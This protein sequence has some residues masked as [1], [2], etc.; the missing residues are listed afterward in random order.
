VKRVVIIGGGLAGASAAFALREAGFDGDVTLVG[1]ERRLPYERPPLSKAYLRGDEAADKALVRSAAEYQASG[2]DLVTGVCAVAIDRSAR[3]VVLETERELPFDR[4]LLATGMTARRLE[5]PG[6]GLE[7]VFTLRTFADADAIRS[8]AERADRVVVIGGGWIGSEVAA[9]LR[10]MGLAV[11]I[12]MPE[13]QPLE[14]VL[15][16]EVGSIYGQLHRDKGVE[17]MIGEVVA[18]EGERAARGVQLR[19]GTTVPAQLTVAG[20]GATARVE[21][22]REAGLALADG[23]IAVDAQLRTSD[24]R[25]YAAGDV[26]AAFNPRYGTRLRVEHWDNAREQGATAA[27]NMCG[28]AE[29]Y[30]RTPYFYSDQFDLG[31]E[32]RGYARGWQDVVVRGDLSRREFVAFWLR[33]GRVAAAMNANAWD[34]AAALAGLVERAAPAREVDGYQLK[35]PAPAA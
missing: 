23:G 6:A 12:V 29:E 21:L 18:L 3:R 8:A 1:D 20:I 2:I 5:I 13:Q 27:R 31:M 25:I 10:Q 17:L 22:A 28:S 24:P 11:T 7:G 26:A 19:D 34:D 14:R 32:Y 33:D 4:L 35:A 9:S 16:A 30:A 15:G